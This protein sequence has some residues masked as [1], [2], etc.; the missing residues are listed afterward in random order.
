MWSLSRFTWSRTPFALPNAVYPR[1]SLSF[2]ASIGIVYFLNPTVIFTPASWKLHRGA[3]RLNIFISIWNQ[4]W[5]VTKV[6][7]SQRL[8]PTSG[9]EKTVNHRL[10]R[11][12]TQ[13]A[14]GTLPGKAAPRGVMKAGGG[15]MIPWCNNILR[16]FL[17]FT[18][19]G[20]NIGH[21]T[22]EGWL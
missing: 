5:S 6:F 7:R 2:T 17:L 3:R 1:S 8:P 14:S 18:P 22:H 13:E 11:W 15:T 10:G 20:V 9:P 4:T 21:L 12:K 19:S 16:H